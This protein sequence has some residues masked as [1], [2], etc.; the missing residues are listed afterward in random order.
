MD[1]L[2]QAGKGNHT[3]KIQSEKTEVREGVIE[4]KR[5]RERERE[6]GREGERERRGREKGKVRENER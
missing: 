5:E 1:K 2:Y 3:F 6:R 4:S